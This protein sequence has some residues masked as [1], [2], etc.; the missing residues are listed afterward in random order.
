MMKWESSHYDD[1][2]TI[3]KEAELRFWQQNRFEPF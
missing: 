1:V 3:Q 2:L